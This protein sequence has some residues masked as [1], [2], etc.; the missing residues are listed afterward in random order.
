MVKITGIDVH[1]KPK[2]CPEIAEN[3]EKAV[4]KMQGRLEQSFVVPFERQQ[5]QSRPALKIFRFSTVHRGKD[6]NEMDE[7]RDVG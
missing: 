4:L 3:R 6:E 1:I 5:D 7:N 2:D